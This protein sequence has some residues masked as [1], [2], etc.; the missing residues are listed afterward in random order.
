MGQMQPVGKKQAAFFCLYFWQ[1][2]NR[3][4]R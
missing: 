3:K 2:G 1:F 4:Y